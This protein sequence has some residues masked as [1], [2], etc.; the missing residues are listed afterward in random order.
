M[1]LDMCDAESIVRQAADLVESKYVFPQK[2]AEIAAKVRER[3]A[4]GEFADAVVDRDFII[5][6]TRLFRSLSGDLHLGF[7]YFAKPQ[8]MRDETA[9]VFGEVDDEDILEGRISNCGFHAVRRLG[10]N[11]GYIDLRQFVPVEVG[12]ETA[13]AAMSLVADT[14]ALII[15]LR[16]NEGGVLD[17]ITHIASYL[18]EEPVQMSSRYNHITGETTDYWTSTEVPGRRFGL[19]PLYLLTS[20]DSFSGGEGFAYDL[21]QHGRVTIVGEKTPGAANA[22]KIYTLTPHVWMAITYAVTTNPVSKTN[23][24]GVGVEPDIHVEAEKALDEAHRLALLDIRKTLD[25]RD[26]PERILDEY[27]EEVASELERLSGQSPQD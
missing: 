23:F 16:E 9:F 8:P 5:S 24:E 19:K 13:T 2:G 25:A 20:A 17:M 3:I 11:V 18:F 1:N 6:L 10:G 14:E 7:A 26:W 27:K 15:D 12:G 21:R 22:T 4:A